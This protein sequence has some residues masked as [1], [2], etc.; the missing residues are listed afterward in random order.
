MYSFV[1]LYKCYSIVWS[2]GLCFFLCRLLCLVRIQI[3]L[4][5]RIRQKSEKARWG[6]EKK[7]KRNVEPKTRT[8]AHAQPKSKFQI[9]DTE[10]VAVG[11]VYKKANA[12]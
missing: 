11:G 6:K 10:K 3:E 7:V 2:L 5:H 8:R 1:F 12:E 9:T 4:C